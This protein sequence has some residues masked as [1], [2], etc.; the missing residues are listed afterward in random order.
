MSAMNWAL[1]E[2]AQLF[3]THPQ[4]PELAEVLIQS[5]Q[6]DSRKAKRGDLF[7]CLIGERFDA[8]DFAHEVRDAG[9]SAL[10]VSRA[11]NL[12][13]PQI[14][15]PDTRLA[16]G[17]LAFAWRMRHQL[18]IFAVVGSNG[19][20]SSKEMLASVC[21][22]HWGAEQVLVT[23]GNLNN[24]IGVPLT[25]LGL[26]AG[27]RAAVIEMGMNHP[28]E[29]QRLAAMVRP[30]V[31]LL[32]NAQREH[33]EFMGSVEA[34]ARENGESFAFLPEGGLAVFPFGT[35]FEAI[36]QTQAQGRRQVRFGAG[37]AYQVQ[38]SPSQLCTPNGVLAFNPQFI[39]GHNDQN[40]AGVLAAAL[41]S[42]IPMQAVQRGL[43]AFEPV[44]GR[45]KVVCQ[46]PELLLIDDSYNANPDSVIA[47]CDVL[48][49][50]GNPAVLVLGDMGEVGAQSA[51]FHAEVGAYA[52]ACGVS[53]LLALGA[54]THH[55][56]KA[57]GQGAE[58][59]ESV[60][61]LTESLMALIN[62]NTQAVLVKGSRFMKMERVVQ[63]VMNQRAVA[64]EG[65]QHAS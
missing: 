41:E 31:V 13:I 44:Q 59:F 56:V 38:R 32:T 7:V 29:I 34:V 33:Q 60:E 22:A 6:T 58:H 11:L 39:G 52:K 50:V 12:D 3:P 42:S 21:R 5:I 1:G 20:T 16:L 55:S 43:E 40:A 18:H 23:Q 65:G 37:S 47:A 54:D 46:T 19:K 28:G 2:I 17:A 63:A 4:Q 15:V 30:D 8:H 62:K 35:D 25:L 36:W 27:H 9:A 14:I 57:F 51:Q 24:D 61:Q 64:T 45:M 26:N 48:A 49:T 10:I 53:R